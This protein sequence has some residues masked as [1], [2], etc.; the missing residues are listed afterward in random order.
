MLID[1]ERRDKQQYNQYPTFNTGQIIQTGNQYRNIGLELHFRQNKPDRHRTFPPTPA[2]AYSQSHMKRFSW[3]TTKK[4]I[5]TNSRRFN[6][7]NY[8][9]ITQV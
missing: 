5:L 6:L 9:L 3:Q 2:N 1:L 4:K 8:L 7:L